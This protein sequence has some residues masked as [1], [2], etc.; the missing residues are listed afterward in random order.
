MNLETGSL[1]DL[2]KKIKAQEYKQDNNP[3]YIK[4]QRAAKLSSL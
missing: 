1:E 2:L 4:N 3:K